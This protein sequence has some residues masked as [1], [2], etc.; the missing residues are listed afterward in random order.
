MVK[1]KSRQRAS[2][3][4]TE[5]SWCRPGERWTCNTWRLEGGNKAGGMLRVEK[6]GRRGCK[7]GRQG[8]DHDDRIKGEIACRTMTREDRTG[9]N[10]SVGNQGKVDEGRGRNRLKGIRRTWRIIKIDRQD[11]R[12]WE[13]KD[14]VD[15]SRDVKTTGKGY[16]MKGMRCDI[17]RRRKKKVEKNKR[18]KWGQ[19]MKWTGQWGKA[20]EF[21]LFV[22]PLTNIHSWYRLN[23]H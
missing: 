20:Q 5:P 2:C 8:K 9:D 18:K 16:S 4:L 17:E 11:K 3:Q 6:W 23:K 10:G 21:K 12:T 13:Y 15:S 22:Y 14:R 1:M 19:E 7:E